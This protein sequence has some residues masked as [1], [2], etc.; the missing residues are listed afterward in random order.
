MPTTLIVD[1]DP[2]FAALYR[3]PAV[4]D[5]DHHSIAELMPALAAHRAGGPQRDDTAV[6]VLGRRPSS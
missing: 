3:E 1:Q 5:D 2:A 4:V 6:V